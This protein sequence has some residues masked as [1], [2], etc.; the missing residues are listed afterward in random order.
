MVLR[1]AILRTLLSYLM[2][3]LMKIP[4]PAMNPVMRMKI[5]ERSLLLMKVKRM[6]AAIIPTVRLC[7]R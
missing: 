3:R 2:K 7:L 1:G 6:T 5:P 4:P